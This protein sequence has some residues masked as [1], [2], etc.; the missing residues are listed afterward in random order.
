MKRITGLSLV[1]LL[2]LASCASTPPSKTVWRIPPDFRV[3]GYF[4]GWSGDPAKVNYRALTHVVYA[5]VL[6]DSAGTLHLGTEPAKKDSDQDDVL[7]D[8]PAKLKDL[9]ARAHAAGVKV[10]VSLGGWN[11]GD[12]GAFEKISADPALTAAFVKNTVD[13]LTAYHLDGVDLDW[14]FPTEATAAA[15]ASLAKALAEPLH[16]LKAELS[17]AV[18]ATEGRGK[19]FTDEALAAADW[20]NIMAYDGGTK[21]NPGNHST[22]AYARSS[23]DYWVV[24]RKLTASKAVLGVPFYGRS[25]SDRISRSYS[26]LLKEF[27][28]AWTADETGGFGYNGFDTLRSK[29]V[30]Q[31]RL[32]SGGVMIWQIN[33]DAEGKDSLLQLI[34]DTVKEPVE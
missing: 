31:A 9:T 27:P 15:Y 17:L 29:V 20:I 22:Y 30:N 8:G 10:M 1:L 19:N 12:T 18:T 7:K 21:A 4:P 13:F 5:F 28:Q 25:L 23:L 14:E 34:Y 6:A 11:H 26:S 32:R 2:A 3:V 24:Q 33:Q 16:G